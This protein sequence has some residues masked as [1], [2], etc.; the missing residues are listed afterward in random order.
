[1]SAWRDRTAPVGAS[2]AVNLFSGR[3]IPGIGGNGASVKQGVYDWSALMFQTTRLSVALLSQCNRLHNWRRARAAH[4]NV[5]GDVVAAPITD[6]MGRRE[7]LTRIALASPCSPG[8][9]SQSIAFAPLFVA[10]EGDLVAVVARS[11]RAT[12]SRSEIS[13]DISL[14]RSS[15]RRTMLD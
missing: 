7:C 12:L 4:C 1:M 8:S 6:Q 13:S 14:K 2:E 10:D 15:L 5:H 3:S 9:C 11:A